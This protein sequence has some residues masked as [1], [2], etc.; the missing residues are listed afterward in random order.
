MAVCQVAGC[1]EHYACRLK[2]KGIQVHPDALPNRPRKGRLTP[3]PPNTDLAKVEYDERPNGTRMPIL[4]PDG[5]PV[6]KAQAQR[7]EQK[8]DEFRRQLHSSN[9]ST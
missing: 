8:L 5:S 7:Q 6:R 9:P 3:T 4:N 1:D 2:A